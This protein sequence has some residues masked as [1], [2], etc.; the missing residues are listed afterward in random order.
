MEDVPEFFDNLSIIAKAEVILREDG[1][2]NINDLAT[3]IKYK[4]NINSLASQL[5]RSPKFQYGTTASGDGEGE[6]IWRIV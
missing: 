2:R 5:S 6:K 4:G 1:P 3:E